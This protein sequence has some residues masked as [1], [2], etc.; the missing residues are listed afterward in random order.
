MSPGDDDGPL[1]FDEEFESPEEAARRRRERLA[2]RRDPD[3][4]P[5]PES[6]PLAPRARLQAGASKYGWFVGVIGVL[7]I[8]ILLLQGF[9]RHGEKGLGIKRGGGA[10]PFAAP[11]A[12]APLAAA[13]HNDVN[14]AVK[15]GQGD[16]GKVPA[17]S[18]RRP[19]VLNLCALYD[20]GPVVLAFFAARSGKCIEQ[21]DRLDDAARRHPDV[22]FAAVSIRGNLADVRRIIRAR[23]WSFPVGY[24][25]DGVLADAYGVVICPQI[26]FIRR[27]GTVASTSL[28]ELDAPELEA[29]VAA[30][31]RGTTGPTG[32]TGG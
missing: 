18:V 5:P 1:G 8:A 28:G 12:L 13:D 24:D 29:K 16:A 21:L 10:P 19:D 15:A 27:G 23:R 9:G 22:S 30:L 7:L 25:H 31:E 11:L 32:A 2:R 20:K 26:T 4:E 14:V 6:D 3:L 17:C